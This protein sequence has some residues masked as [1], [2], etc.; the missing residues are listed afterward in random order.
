MAVWLQNLLVFVVVLGCIA[1]IARG[2]YRALQGR[3]NS[4]AGCGTCQGC[5]PSPKP[6]SAPTQKVQFIPVEMLGRRKA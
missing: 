6:E 1:W 5:A 2:A 3:K 4:L